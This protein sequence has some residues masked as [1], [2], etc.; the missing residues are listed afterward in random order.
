M[1]K[2]TSKTLAYFIVF[3]CLGLG[4]FF[5]VNTLFLSSPV[6][7]QENEELVNGSVSEVA[8]KV[9]PAIV[10]VSNFSR[11]GDMFSQRNTERTGSGVIIDKK[12]HIVTNNHVVRDADR[13][14][15]TLVDG[16][17]KTAKVIGTDPRTD[18]AVIKIDV[19]NKVSPAEFGDSDQLLVGQQVVAIGNPLGLRFARSV[20]SGVVSGL[21]RIISTEE[22]FVFRLIQTDA[23]INPGN[24]G[25]ALVDLNGRLI[26]INTIKIAVPGFEGM[27]FSIPSNQV[28][29]VVNELIK[30]GRVQRPLMGIK[31]L[32]EVTQDE[33]NYYNLPVDYGVAIEPVFGGPSAKAGIQKYDIITKIN[34]QKVEN[35]LDLQDKIFT[36]KIG[37][38]V[39]VELVRMNQNNRQSKKHTVKVKLSSDG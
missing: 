1:I 10:G 27:G 25:G 21:N 6:V 22:G 12:G 18:L 29:G 39:N 13:I 32:G 5:A 23:A 26:G 19:K 33:A 20:T 15:V 8:K 14:V 17:E 4:V 34:G 36:Q 7:T 24:S 31:I 30:N 9:S 16:N 2:S 37:Q 38:V 11:E 3:F 35:G 28:K